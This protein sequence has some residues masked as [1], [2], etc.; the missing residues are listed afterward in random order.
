MSPTAPRSIDV[1]DPELPLD[2]SRPRDAELKAREALRAAESEGQT[3]RAIEIRT[4]LARLSAL[5][6][7]LPEA[8]HLLFLVHKSLAA[9]SEPAPHLR[10]LL[11]QGRLLTLKRT[12]AEAR[13]FLLRAWELATKSGHDFFAIDA[14]QM[15]AL[16]EP[17]KQR[18]AWTEKALSLAER[19]ADPRAHVWRGPLLLTMGWHYLELMQF[20]RAKESFTKAIPGLTDPKALLSARCG[21]STALRALHRTE[22]ALV[23]SKENLN[24]MQR[25]RLEDG[26]VL[27]EIGEC[28]HTLKRFDE[29]QTYFMMAYDRLAKDE[30]LAD[31]QS[32]R[33]N[34]LKRLGKKSGSE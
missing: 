11:E 17:P 15:M 5:E 28:L 19:S 3:A 21:L 34:R 29:A 32:A 20:E 2:F 10:Y 23:I 1:V 33:L 27:E 25:L 8:E 24:E 7:K 22:E 4:Q 16:N 13:N 18:F 30:W 6:G 9:V 14:A 31:N 26:M 12:P